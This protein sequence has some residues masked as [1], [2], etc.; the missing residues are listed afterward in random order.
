MA[1]IVIA[2]VGAGTGATDQES[3]HA[4]QVGARLAEAGATVVCGGLGGVM[5]AAA[6]GATSAGGTAVGILPGADRRAGNRHLSVAI[7][8]G[9][10]EARNTVIVRSA[11]AVIAIGGEYGTLSEIAFALKLGTPVIGLRTWQLSRDGQLDTGILTADD[12]AE[13]VDAALTAARRGHSD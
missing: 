7:P 8:T 5:E 6:R 10:G 3:S 2:V 12:A 13:A 1:D 11:D 9:L 4:Q